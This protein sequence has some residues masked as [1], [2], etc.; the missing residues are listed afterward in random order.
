MVCFHTV[1]L[2]SLNLQKYSIYTIL[3]KPK[4]A[5]ATRFSCFSHQYSTKPIWSQLPSD[6][7]LLF[8]ATGVLYTNIVSGSSSCMSYLYSRDRDAYVFTDKQHHTEISPSNRV[9]RHV[10]SWS[11]CKQAVARSVDVT[12]TVLHCYSLYMWCTFTFRDKRRYFSTY[13][14][15]RSECL[16]RDLQA[17]IKPLPLQPQLPLKEG[18]RLQRKYS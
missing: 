11:K 2:H 14:S 9:P 8:L 15:C 4:S 10:H 5:C 18:Q 3:S 12:L 6:G 1:V 13:M 16:R 17:T 7:L